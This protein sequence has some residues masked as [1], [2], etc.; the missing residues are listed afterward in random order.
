MRGG[1]RG[2]PFIGELSSQSAADA[3]QHLTCVTFGQHEPR[4]MMD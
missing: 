3:A 2:I 1:G 4:P